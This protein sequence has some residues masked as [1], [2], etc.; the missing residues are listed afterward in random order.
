MSNQ[1]KKQGG[2]QCL[3]T[4]LKQRAIPF[5]PVSL[6]QYIFSYSKTTPEM[7]TD[8]LVQFLEPRRVDPLQYMKEELD[9]SEGLTMK[10]SVKI[11]LLTSF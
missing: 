4:L 5:F 9:K 6:Q 11:L 8:N 2:N 7:I 10:Y 3:L 1:K